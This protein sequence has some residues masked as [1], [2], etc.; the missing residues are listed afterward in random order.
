MDSE[1]VTLGGLVA[2]ALLL[3]FGRRLFWLF[4]GVAGFFAGMSLAGRFVENTTGIISAGLLLGV[5]GAVLAV[6]VQR[7]A[8]FFGGF[9]AG[10]LVLG[11]LVTG[12]LGSEQ[13]TWLP[14]I[15]G[16][17]LGALL[18]SVVFDWALLVLSALMGALLVASFVR[19]TFG[20]EQ[21][22]GTI[23]I[24][25]LFIAGVVLQGGIKRR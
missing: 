18:M 7:A 20:L 21:P 16:G 6:F 5:I 17:V 15:L 22:L 8:I 24:G 14:F 4:V 3:A 13:M 23:L 1:V 9:L 11:N 25:G 19:Q 2:G 12:L 10:G